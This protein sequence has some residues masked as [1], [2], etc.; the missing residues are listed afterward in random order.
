MDTELR[1]RI[2]ITAVP[3]G[4]APLKI[5]EQWI[6][7]DMRCLW[8]RQSSF[9]KHVV[10]KKPAQTGPVYVVLQKDALDALTQVAP[11][12]TKWWNNAGYPESDMGIWLFNAESVTVLEAV[13]SWSELA[14]EVN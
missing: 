7:V 12:A 14:G 13:P 9:G 2:R 5:K 4:D 3:D 6:G 8:Y 11:E 10:S 1:G